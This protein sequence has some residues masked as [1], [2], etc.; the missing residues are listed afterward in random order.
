M[1]I[2]IVHLY[3]DLLNMYSDMGNIVC[4]QKRCQWR[5]IE[6]KILPVS[7]NQSFVGKKY[8]LLYSGGGQ[9]RYQAVLCRDLLRKKPSLKQ[10]ALQGMP[11]LTTCASFQ[12]FGHY[13]KS[14]EGQIMPGI[15][16][17]DAYTVGSDIRKIGNIA[18]KTDFLPNNLVGFENHSGNTYLKGETKP[19]G[20]VIKGFGNNGED[21]FEGAIYK[22][23]IGSY[24]HGPILPKN[25][26]L[27]DWLLTKALERKYEKK[28]VLP[29]LDD[30]LEWQAHEKTSSLV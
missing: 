23:V 10:A 17:F 7:L 8:D 20:K 12:L 15:G 18:V 25:P 2:T 1:R 30:T 3:P 28:I 24:L 21:G 26:H 14:K 5:G 6:A 27:C 22:N 9:D 13:F 29:P 19:L 11:I 16:I 4:L